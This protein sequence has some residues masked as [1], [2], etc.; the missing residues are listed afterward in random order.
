[1]A[2]VR[3]LPERT[4]S[5]FLAETSPLSHYYLLRIGIH[6]H[7]GR[8]SADVGEHYVR[9][10]Q[11]V[12]RTTRGLEIG[13]VLA[14]EEDRAAKRQTAKLQGA[15]LQTDGRLIRKMTSEDHLLKARLEQNQQEAFT[16]C[17]EK[18][19]SIDSAATLMDVEL[20]FDGKSLFFH[21]L[22]EV[23]PQAEAVTKELAEVY[24]AASGLQKFGEMLT[25]GCGPDCGTE[26]ASGCG[27]EGGC[28]VCSL[29]SACHQ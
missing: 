15:K 8:F 29:S 2:E 28:A 1:M 16:A 5:Y 4:G 3:S 12:C 11:V 6:G 23:T 24:E 18:L 25:V 21:F 22:G 27:S 13:H 19:A 9:G 14:A 20:L 7:V 17:Q 26:A 10:D